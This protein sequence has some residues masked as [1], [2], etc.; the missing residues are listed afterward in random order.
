MTLMLVGRRRHDQ[1]E[2]FRRGDHHLA[3][4]AAPLVAAEVED[5]WSLTS[6]PPTVPPNCCWLYGAF[7]GVS[8]GV[9]SQSPGRTMTNAEPFSSLVP[10][11]VIMLATPAE[12]PPN[13]A[14]NW[15]VMS[16]TSLTVSMREAARAEL[17]RALQ[18]Q[19][20]RVVVR[21]VDVGA[22]VPHLLPPTFTAF[23]PVPAAT[24]LESSVRRRK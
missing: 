8:G 6:G 21:A 13:S 23:E 4:L 16:C 24:T 2:R 18:R 10:L 7:T 11:L 15:L 20:L 3:A 12:C 17:R 19:P 22:E 5:A 1:A 14:E 9:A